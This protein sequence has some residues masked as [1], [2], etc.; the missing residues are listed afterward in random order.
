MSVSELEKLT[1]T[2]NPDGDTRE[3]QLYPIQSVDVSSSKDAFSISPPG[4]AASENLLMGIGGMQADIS[5]NAVA[6]DDGSD[7]ANGT[8]SE[9]ITGVTEQLTYLED[10]I[11]SPDFSASWHL[12]HDTGAGFND[13]SV[14]VENVDYTLISNDSPKWK[15]YT[16]RLR[17]GESIG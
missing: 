15:S 5:I 1:I 9:A 16:L 11:Q 10:T 14:F 6:Y 17:R 4:L 7:R 3:Y 12:N 2:L 8:H 13:D